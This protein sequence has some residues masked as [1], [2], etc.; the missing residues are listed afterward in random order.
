MP[1]Y[2]LS[3]PDARDHVGFVYFSNGL[4]GDDA[5][6]VV[7]THRRLTPMEAQA[8]CERIV[9]FHGT[10]D[11]LGSRAAT[12]SRLAA[13]DYRG[14]KLEFMRYCVIHVGGRAAHAVCLDSLCDVKLNNLSHA[15][16]MR[17]K[18]RLQAADDIIT[19]PSGAPT[20]VQPGHSHVR[21]TRYRRIVVPTTTHGDV[22][23]TMSVFSDPDVRN[24]VTVRTQR[25]ATPSNAWGALCRAVNPKRYV[26]RSVLNPAPLPE[27]CDSCDSANDAG[28]YYVARTGSFVGE[29]ERH[30]MLVPRGG[31]ARALDVVPQ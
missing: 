29:M 7:V 23:V 14:V 10:T 28:D 31:R 3:I 11:K 12:G 16:L 2:K 9:A 24:G 25:A 21:A 6:S 30:T 1:Q 26:V 20:N 19:D 27:S 8:W 4:R 5:F 15:R 18:P 13:G 22:T 17:C